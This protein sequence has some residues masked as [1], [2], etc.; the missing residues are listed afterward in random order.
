MSILLGIGLFLMYSVDIG[1]RYIEEGK[2]HPDRWIMKGI[3]KHWG[4][5]VR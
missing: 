5:F 2:F 4:S 3:R 1:A